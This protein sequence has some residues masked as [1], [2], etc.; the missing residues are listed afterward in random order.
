MMAKCFVLF[1]DIHPCFIK[2]EMS[3]ALTFHF[4]KKIKLDYMEL[5]SSLVTG[6]TFREND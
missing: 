1:M 3:I 2:I 4:F 5:T 6:N